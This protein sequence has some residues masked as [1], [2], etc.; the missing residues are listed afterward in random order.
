MARHTFRACIFY[1]FYALNGILLLTYVA[2]LIFKKDIHINIGLK[3][4]DFKDENLRLISNLYLPGNKTT[5]STCELKTI[6]IDN[7]FVLSKIPRTILIETTKNFT[8]IYNN[9]TKANRDIIFLRYNFH[10]LNYANNNVLFHTIISKLNSTNE[11]LLFLL[12]KI[13]CF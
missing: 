4:S 10:N 11:K 6:D 2:N 12:K 5:N 1:I 9:Y 3:K 13:Y 7:G 8:L